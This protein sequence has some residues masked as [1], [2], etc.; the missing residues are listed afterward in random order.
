MPPQD[1]HL[2]LLQVSKKEKRKRRSNKQNKKVDNQ[3]IKKA[4]PGKKQLP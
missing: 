4:K 2:T 3:A 1:A